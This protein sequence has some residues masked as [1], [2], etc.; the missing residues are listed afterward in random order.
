MLKETTTTTIA[1]KMVGSGGRSHRRIMALAASS[2]LALTSCGESIED[3]G[4]GTPLVEGSGTG[5]PGEVAT[6]DVSSVGPLAPPGVGGQANTPSTATPPIDEPGAGGGAVVE[7]PAG[8]GGTPGTDEVLIDDGLPGRAL[9]RRLSN[10]E[11]AATMKTLLGYALG[12]DATDYWA[13]F[14]EDTVVNGFT[15]NTDVQDVGPALAEQ[16][17]VTAEALTSRIVQDVDLLLGCSLSEGESCIADFVAR[18]GKRAW[19]RPLTEAEQSEL[20]ALAQSEADAVTG[21]QVLVQ[22]LLNSP[23]FLYRPEV[24]VPVAGE[25]YTALTSWEVATRLSYFLTGTMPDEALL[26]AAEADTLLTAEGVEAQARR[27]LATDAARE[28]V[29][30]FFSGWLNL[31]AVDRLQRD[32]E[33]FPNWDSRLPPLFYEETRA[34]AI[35]VVF[36]GGGDFETLM[37]ASY[38]YGDPSLAEYYGGTAGPVENGI[39]R[40]E[41]PPTQRSGLLTHAS[42]LATHSKEIQ[43]DPVI[44]GKFVRERMLCQGVPAPP[45]DLMLT[46]PTITPGSTT[47]E[48]FIQHQ[49]DP[50]CATCHDLMDPIGLTFEHYDPIGQWR[51]QDAGRDVDASG[52][53]TFTDVSGPIDGVVEMASRLAE[54]E[55]ATECFAR[56]WFR[57]AFGRAEGDSEAARMATITSAF[58]AAD[59]RVQELMIALTLT[60]DFRFLAQ[61]TTQ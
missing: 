45:P 17:V 3:P 27:L 4:D 19:R 44:R 61:D 41:L 57:F 47:R 59:R 1:G 55:L 33:H 36:D 46:A 38:T 2:L 58:D 11:Y 23:N 53:L 5:G 14:P 15:N 9:I 12:D 24:G 25:T 43:T 37:T 22:A 21:V 6:G 56:N 42:F 18:F 28:N 50:G 34:F 40:I 52:E 49:E 29:G 16:Y 7:P 26:A 39:A 30:A 35:N 48:R 8:A 10:E 54:S 31:H 60:P 20:L 51:D 13:N 32:A